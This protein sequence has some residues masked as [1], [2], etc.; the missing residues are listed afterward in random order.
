MEAIGPDHH[1]NH[2]ILKHNL[3]DISHEPT[4]SIEDFS[5]GGQDII[6]LIQMEDEKDKYVSLLYLIID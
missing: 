5:F 1:K 2:M 4:F 3:D 6:D